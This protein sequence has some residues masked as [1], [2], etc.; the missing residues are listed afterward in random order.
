MADA[1]TV[2]SKLQ[3]IVGEQLN[4]SVDFTNQIAAGDIISAPVVKVL[5]QSTNESANHALRGLAFI[6]TG[7]IVNVTINSSSLRR[8]TIY[9]VTFSCTS[10]GGGQP[11]NVSAVLLVEIVY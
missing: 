11:K 4:L 1:V 5:N 2:P 3:M 8:G 10:T 7:T 6:S 9:T